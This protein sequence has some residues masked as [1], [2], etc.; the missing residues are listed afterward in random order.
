VDV[1]TIISHLALIISRPLSF[2]VY[3]GKYGVNHRI[4]KLV[5]AECV[6]K[7]HR[8]FILT[9][10][11]EILTPKKI[12]RPPL[13]PRA[14]L[15]FLK[16]IF[17]KLSK[18]VLGFRTSDM[19]FEGLGEMLEGDSADIMCQKISTSVDGGPS[20]GSRVRRPGSEDPHWR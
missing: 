19:T 17:L 12:R 14:V 9:Q 13:S 18:V 2:Y 10:K 15:V 11:K 6:L 20:A 1:F 3:Y 4:T 8:G 16:V 7:L 5:Q